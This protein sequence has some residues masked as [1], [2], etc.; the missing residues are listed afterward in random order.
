M[1]PSRMTQATGEGRPVTEC[2]HT[3]GGKMGGELNALALTHDASQ[4][5][6]WGSPLLSPAPSNHLTIYTHPGPC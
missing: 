5:N 1:E 2:R 4:L 6:F 3:N